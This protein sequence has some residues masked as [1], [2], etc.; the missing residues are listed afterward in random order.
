MKGGDLFEQ[1]MSKEHFTEAEAREIMLGVVDALKYCTELNILHRDIKPENLLLTTKNVEAAVVKISDFGF[2][3]FV[4]DDA[5]QARTVCGTPGYVSPE[6]LMEQA[7]TS[8]LDIWSIGV[9]LYILLSGLPPFYH[10]D[11]FVLFE[12]IKKCEYSFKDEIWSTVSSE[13]KDL[14]S[15]LLVA[16]YEKRLDAKGVLEHAWMRKEKLEDSSYAHEVKK[17]ENKHIELVETH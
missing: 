11:N 7:Q 9:V 3:R 13:A 14:I 5:D 16:D 1:V 8:K 15:K 12:Q 10:E 6:V 2:S 17:E 4:A